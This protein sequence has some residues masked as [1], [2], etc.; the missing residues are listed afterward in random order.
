MSEQKDFK[1]TER[2][3][4]ARDDA[5]EQAAADV[6]QADATQAG[7]QLSFQAE[8][9]QL[10]DLMIHSLYSNK[11]IF[12]RELISNSSDALDRYRFEALTDDALE[13]RDDLEIRIETDS[14]KR[15]LTITDNGIGMSRAELIRNIGTIARSGTKE[16]LDQL[17]RAKKDDDQ[18]ALELIGQF[19]VGFYSAF[20]VADRVELVTRRAGEKLATIWRSSGDGSYEVDDA[21][22]DDLSQ[23]ETCGTSICLHL[24]PHDEEAGLE[25][26][27]A[28]WTLRQIIKRY[29]DFVRYPIKLRV[30][31]QEVERD[32][33]G[34]PKA[35]AEPETVVS[36]ETINSMKAI[37]TRRESEVEDSEYH[38]FYRM[39]SHD[40]EKPLK[41]VSLNAEG[42]IEYRALLFIPSR[43]PFDLYYREAEPGLQLYVR[44]VK[45]MDR[46]QALLPAYLRFVRGV[47]D[48]SDLPLN[49]S[50]E[51]LQH[52]RQLTQ[53][54]RGIVKKLLSTLE[55]MLDKQRDEYKAFFGELGRALKEGIVTDQDNRERIA[56][57]LL[58]DS[59]AQDEQT[60]LSEY[61]ERMPEE[62]S[63]IF[64]ITAES[65][66]IAKSSPHLEAFRKKGY[67]VLL[68]TDPV[69]EFV[70]QHLTELEGKKL[71]SI[72]A[73]E[74]ELGSEEDK[75]QA[76]KQR[77]E[78]EKELSE[79]LEVL[80]KKL[81]DHVKSVRVSS[82]LTESPVCLVSEEGD[83]SP[84]LQKVLRKSG[85]ALPVVK[86][87]LEL[88][89]AHPVIEKL[90]GIA[91]ND[92][93][94]AQ[95][96]DYAQLLL[97][98]AL[99]AEGSELPDPAGFSKLVAQ[100][101][102]RAG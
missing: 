33:E 46:C 87:I 19:G 97:G 47:V 55:E 27:T 100:L 63:D 62:Q 81:D 43:A 12:L 24:K 78:A 14:D 93:E 41:R 28:E 56:K 102:T 89:A 76:E 15:T 11:E 54:R 85:E 60:T 79:L 71:R 52:D 90:A 36:H 42:R 2:R 80:Q 13:E 45:I 88:N 7:H 30:E 69:D 23:I 35:G 101:M 61:I 95:L 64:Y 49:V 25:D 9:K 91:K 18:N 70:V 86:R 59:S 38:E 10:L 37:W 8:T 53:I 98:Q 3:H 39:I 32:E 68:M 48:S 40:W 96:D 51:L 74:V 83:Q 73:G 66:A 82:R 58:F 77:E 57:L 99:L 34:N 65:Q 5:D 84:Y 22:I 4:W 29:S 50:R 31:R 94:N 44:N 92:A 21:Q 72:G 16:L 17:S 1:V 20:M 67:E 26:F 6:A 75:K